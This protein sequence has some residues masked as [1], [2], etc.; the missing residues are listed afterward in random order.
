MITMYNDL[1]ENIHR[2]GREIRN[3]KWK[4]HTALPDPKNT[5]FEINISL[6]DMK[7]RFYAAEGQISELEVLES[8]REQTE[9]K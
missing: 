1:K 6:D 5:I 7:N 9:K 4:H 3:E 2:M 8:K